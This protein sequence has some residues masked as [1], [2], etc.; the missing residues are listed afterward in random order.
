DDFGA[1]YAEVEIPVAMADV[2]DE[3]R[4]LLVEAAAEQDEELLERYLEGESLSNEDVRRALRKAV[5]ANEIVPVFC[6]A[7]LRN[8]GIQRL[9]DGVVDYL[10]A[11]TEV[12]AVRG[13]DPISGEPAERPSS[14][15]APLAAL[16]FKIMADPHVGKLTFLRVYSGVLSSG[17][18]VFNPR[19]GAKERIGRLLQMHANKREE[20]KRVHAG[21]IVAAVGLKSVLTGDTIC[22]PDHPVLLES[23]HFPDP[24]L[25]IAIEP[26][27]KADQEKLATALQ[28]LS[29]EDPTFRVSTDPE[30]G[31]TLIEGMGELHLE[32]LVDR[33]R[34][35]YR[36]EAN[37]GR[38]Q[39]AYRET[40][41]RAARSEE[42]FVRQTGGRGQFGHV[43]LELVPGESGSGFEFVNGI[44]GGAIPREYIPA[45]EKGVKEALSLGAVAGFPIVDIQVRLVD[46]SYHEVDS[47]ELAFAI[48]GSMAAKAGVLKAD[49]ALLEPVMDVEVVV[50]DGFLGNVIGDLSARRGQISHTEPRGKGVQ[51]VLAHVPLAQMFGYVKDL[52]SMT[53]GRATYTMELDC[54]KEVPESV[55]VEITQR[56]AR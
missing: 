10:P 33:M 48:A 47:S 17:D 28:R 22:D 32:V 27:T 16:A 52:R 20:R 34:R 26:K 38:P 13:S 8:I 42:R 50:P 1:T 7:A 25:K 2:V 49:P 55:A 3:H 43:V 40:I 45:V 29:E 5:I 9:L 4:T 23:M 11:P 36:V 18:Y 19:T 53:Q 51:V 24:V 6:G 41:R 31:Q 37:V 35:E 54:Y 56:R 46:G 21:T 14:D 12:A 30:S 39:V 44:V 15:D